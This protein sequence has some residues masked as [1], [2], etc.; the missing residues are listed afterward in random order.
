MCTHPEACV[1]VLAFTCMHRRGRHASTQAASGA[2]QPEPPV[3]AGLATERAGRARERQ[4]P[5]VGPA[6]FANTWG[7]PGTHRLNGPAS[8]YLVCHAGC[9]V[10][11]P[12]VSDHT[13]Y[14]TYMCG[15]LPGLCGA[16]SA[17][18]SAHP[19]FPQR[20]ALTQGTAS[21]P[22]LSQELNRAARL[23]GAQLDVAMPTYQDRVRDDDRYQSA[24]AQPDAPPV[25]PGDDHHTVTTTEMATLATRGLQSRVS[26]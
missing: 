17:G 23:P 15:P 22:A 10:C 13:R 16:R 2:L 1:G 12:Q 20:N 9:S 5:L 11:R 14:G 7:M 21:T 24:E 18:S 6:Y 4:L 26:F 25:D 8:I 19:N 3:D